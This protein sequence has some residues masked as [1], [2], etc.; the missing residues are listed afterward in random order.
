VGKGIAQ[1]YFA[2]I[3]FEFQNKKI[4]RGDL[5]PT[6]KDGNLSLLR[7]VEKRKPGFRV[8]KENIRFLCTFSGDGNSL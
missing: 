7:R 1:F 5:V 2:T 6:E 3:D 4:K 8:E